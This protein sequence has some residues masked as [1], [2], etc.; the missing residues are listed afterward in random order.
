MRRLFWLRPM[1]AGAAIAF[2]LVLLVFMIWRPV[3]PQ[4]ASGTPQPRDRMLPAD[5][6]AA[7]RYVALGDSTV[8]GIGATSPQRHYVGRLY[9]RLREVYRRAELTNLGAGGATAADVLALQLPLVVERRPDLVTLSVGPNDIT[10][11]RGLDQYERDVAA[12]FERLA[13]E[14]GAVVL[15]NLLPDLGLAPAFAAD[16]QTVLSDLTPRFNAALERQ[17]GR[18][19]AQ[20]VDLYGP[21]HLEV[22]YHAELFS[23]DLYHPS[24]AGYARWADELWAA[25]AGRIRI[26]R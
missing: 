21:S 13:A 19:G 25:I 16:E 8:E 1:L 24:D 20:I 10:Q 22:P 23:A 7:V 18:F 17:A 14:T 11:G 3:Q 6:E 26:G 9:A 4:R 15:V 12:I 5:R 2:V